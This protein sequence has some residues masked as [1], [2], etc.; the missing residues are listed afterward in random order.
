MRPDGP[1]ANAGSSA[2]LAF[3]HEEIAHVLCRKPENVQIPRLLTA[4]VAL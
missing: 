3:R 1:G 2:R 4:K